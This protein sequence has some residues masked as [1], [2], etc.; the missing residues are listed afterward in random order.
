MNII[1]QEDVENLG[2]EFEVVTVKPGYGRNFLI[3]QGK[4]KL[5][6]PKNVEELNKILDARREEEAAAIAKANDI[7]ASMEGLEIVMP[8]KVGEGDK[9]FGSINNADLTKFLNNKGVNVERKHVQILGKNIKRLGK[10]TALVK[11]HREVQKEISFDVIP[12]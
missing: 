2:F 1:L 6:T 10:Y 12:E 5:A 3:P 11:P 4:A 8:A 7:I 9:L